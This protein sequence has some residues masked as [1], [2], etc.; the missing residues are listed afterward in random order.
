MHK[1]TGQ[2]YNI[3]VDSNSSTSNKSR[4]D[5]LKSTLD[6]AHV[7]NLQIEKLTDDDILQL[8]DV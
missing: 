7:L 6:D 5:A 4:K 3:T 1:E 8:F 2:H